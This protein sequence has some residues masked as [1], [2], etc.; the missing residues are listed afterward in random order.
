V[1]E[2]LT[3]ALK[4]DHGGRTVVQVHYTPR[5]ISV[6]VS[7]DGSGTDAGSPSARFPGR[8]GRG[9]VGLRERVDVLGGEFSAGARGD[10]GFLVR[11][12]IPAGRS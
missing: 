2:S 6:E 11:A 5:E 10:G 3:N 9:L 12:R 1:Q 4:Y 7:T 8:G